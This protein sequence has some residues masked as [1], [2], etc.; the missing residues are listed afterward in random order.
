MKITV[1]EPASIAEELGI[2][3][4]DEL[5]EIN[6]RRILDS[7]DY[8]YSEGDPEIS[9][10]VARNGEVVMYDIEKDEGEKVG[11]DFEEMKVLSC[12]N[13]CIFCFVDQNPHG[14][15]QQLYFRDGDYRLSFM[16][17]NYTTMTNAGPAILQRIIDQRLSPQYIS[18]HVTDPVVRARLMG[19]KKDDRILEKIALLHD[20]GID[21]HTQIVLCPGI[22]DG[23]ILERTVADLYRYRKRIVSLA[24]VPVGLTDHRFG[25][26]QLRKVDRPYAEEV[27]DVVEQWQA[28]FRRQTGRGFVYA[29]DEFYIVAGRKLP[30]AAAYDGFPQYENGVGLVRSFLT[31]FRRQA[32]LF[33][34]RLPARRTLTLATGELAAGFMQETVL[35]RLASIGGLTV[36]LEIIPNALFGRSVTVAGLLSGKCLY[37]SLDGK[38]CG[39]LLLLPPDI[40]NADGLLLDDETIPR[41]QE[42]LG[43][44]V[45]VYDGRWDDVIARLKQTKGT[46]HTKQLLPSS[47]M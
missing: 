22:N 44:Q 14:L 33:P 37:L 19:L 41:I 45:M 9:L 26:S 3:P 30:S 39:H 5:L 16:Y 23:K 43:V 38:E 29:S 4:G 8:R 15:R 7:I 21:M 31:D 1:V 12:G 35:P 46:S 32:R 47:S 28:G 2:I 36:R 40:L 6:G 27:L 18:V 11:L 42:R 25:L 13:D 24:I 17:G 34:R 10:K 20:N